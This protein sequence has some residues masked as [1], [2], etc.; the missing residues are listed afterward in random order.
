MLVICDSALKTE[1]FKSQEEHMSLYDV[2]SRLYFG[3]AF[4]DDPNSLPVIINIVKRSIALKYD[5]FVPKIESEARRLI[6]RLRTQCRTDPET[7]FDLTQEMIRFVASTSS[8]CFTNVQLTDEAFQTLLAFTN[9]LNQIVVLTYFLP[10]WIL[11]LLFN[12]KISRTRNQIVAFFE[13]EIQKY[14][15]DPY[16]SDSLVLRTAVD[17]VDERTGKGL[18]NQG[19]GEIIV[20]LL[21]VSSENTALG[22][23]NSLSDLARNPNVWERVRTETSSLLN[24][25]DFRGLFASELLNASVMESARLNSHIFALNRKPMKPNS[26]IG[27]YSIPNDVDCVAL[28]EPMLMVHGAA[29]GIFRNPT[30]YNP[31]RFLGECPEP[32]SPYNV[33]TWGAGVHLCPGK[34]FAIYEIK[35]AI[36]L[37]L[38]NF[39][40]EID[41]GSI[42]DLNYFSPSAFAERK[43]VA[44]LRILDEGVEVET[45]VVM[46]QIGEHRVE[47][48]SDK[49]WL[50]RSYMSPTEQEELYKYACLIS[51]NSAEQ[52]EMRNKASQASLNLA[53]DNVTGTSNTTEKPV[54]W[55]LWATKLWTLLEEHRE[56]LKFPAPPGPN[57]DT[58]TAQLL[59]LDGDAKGQ[60]PV[61]NWG[62]RIHIG[63]S[64][65]FGFGSTNLLLHSG[66]V[67][68]AVFSK[69]E[70]SVKR[71]HENSV[72]D[73]FNEK[74][75]ETFGRFGC[76]VQIHD[77]SVKSIKNNN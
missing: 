2:L 69:A 52:G 18:T 31:D 63:A 21:Y 68:I 65:T 3:D 1:F 66:D 22:L 25:G 27:G 77:S 9:Q 19:V 12:R 64:V 23:T 74:Q 43:V 72:P 56:L 4:S 36:A 44:K 58:L 7:R 49:G 37:V 59:G 10:K 39:Q 6:E 75:V 32:F 41:Q 42:S 54:R 5:T 30:Q 13:P 28:C 47:C 17:Y 33:L 53:Y 62:I 24:R 15:E 20:C 61:V 55:Y 26:T 76:G 73:W 11:R 71:I 50:L 14:R 70:R 29:S 38:Q 34:M 45:G 57:F 16:K 46:H 48:V 40:F 60:D 8:H 35:M 51:S 67:F